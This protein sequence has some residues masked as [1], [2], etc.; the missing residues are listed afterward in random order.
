M[1]CTRS[2]NNA[3]VHCYMFVCLSVVLQENAQKD[4]CVYCF[5]IICTLVQG[6]S[7]VVVHIMKWAAVKVQ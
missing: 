1:Q 5:V 3:V 6:G 4:L 2:A 7:V